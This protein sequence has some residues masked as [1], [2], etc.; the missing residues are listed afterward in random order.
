MNSTERANT[1]DIFPFLLPLSPISPA[2]LHKSTQFPYFPLQIY[3]KAP[4]SPISPVNLRK[5][6][7]IPHIS[8]VNLDQK[9][10]NSPENHQNYPKS[11]LSPSDISSCPALPFPHT[12][13]FPSHSGPSTPLRS[14]GCSAT[15]SNP[16]FRPAT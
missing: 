14:L 11:P 8:P 13:L 16:A 5:S 12:A 15:R 10:L 4:N 9:H 3:A 7:P 6:T 2:N 1:C